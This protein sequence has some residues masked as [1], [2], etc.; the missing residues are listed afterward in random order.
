M[1][2]CRIRA[3][4]LFHTHKIIIIVSDYYEHLM[5]FE[6]F[7]TICNKIVKHKVFFKRFKLFN[8]YSL[9]WI[10]WQLKCFL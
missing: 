1:A 10:L 4:G 6:E 3:L 8:H 7:T 5:Y 2:Y 9:G